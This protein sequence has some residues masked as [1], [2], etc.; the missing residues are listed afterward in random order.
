MGRHGDGQGGADG[1]REQSPRE[2]DGQW[3]RPIPDEEPEGEG[4]A[5]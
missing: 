1:D 5:R 4:N 2:S 3:E